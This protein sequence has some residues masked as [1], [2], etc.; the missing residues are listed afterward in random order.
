MPGDPAQSEITVAPFTYDTL[1]G[2][3]VFGAGA[4]ATRAMNAMAHC[5]EAFYAPAANPITSLMAEEGIR[6]LAR[7]APVAVRRPD[8]LDGR[9]DTLYGAYLAGAAFA[10]AG[11]GLHHKICHVLGGAFDLPHAQTHTIVLAHVV[12]YN[13]PAMAAVA[14]RLD[15]ALGDTGD[16]AAA[17][18][19]LVAGL[20]APMAL[21]ESGLPPDGIDEVI[22]PILA[23]VAPGTPRP[24]DA[25]ALRTLLA[26]AAAGTRPEP[27]KGAAA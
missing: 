13:A 20:G 23:A 1:A 24:V 16:P 10:A 6:A 12:A 3:V 19:D 14:E 21:R 15:R 4:A 22:A 2:R 25:D 8:D 11:S 9:T 17:L 18:F 7:G 5:V 27:T 26:A